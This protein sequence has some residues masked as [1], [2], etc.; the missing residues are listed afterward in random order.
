MFSDDYEQCEIHSDYTS[1]YVTAYYERV[2]VAVGCVSQERSPDGKE[3]SHSFPI[4]QVT[5]KSVKKWLS[6]KRI[7]SFIQNHFTANLTNT[8]LKNIILSCEVMN[9]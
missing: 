2:D 5:T 4:N 6:Y 7:E 8:D 3:V 1:P 9:R